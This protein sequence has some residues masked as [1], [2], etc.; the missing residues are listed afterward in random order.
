[1]DDELPRFKDF[2]TDIKNILEEYK[3]VFIKLNWWAPKD[4]SSWAYDLKFDNLHDIFMALKTSGLLMEMVADYEEWLHGDNQ[5][6]RFT[7]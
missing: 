5:Y 6:K 4:C 1:M 7:K 2:E 3:S